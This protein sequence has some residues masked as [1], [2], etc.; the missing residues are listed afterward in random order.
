MRSPALLQLVTGDFI[1][2]FGDEAQLCVRES[3]SARRAVHLE[4]DGQLVM[5]LAP[6]SSREERA[7]LLDGWYRRQLRDRIPALIATWEP[8]MG[9]SVAAWGVKRMRTRWGSCNPQARRIWL[10]L[11]LARRP[12]S[13]LEYV[14]VHE[15]V[16]L[17][18]RGHNRRFY[19]FMDRFLPDWRLA[20]AQLRN[21]PPD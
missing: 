19:A 12:I 10:S 11:E 5:Q 16:H 2:V 13:C 18:E 20:R 7:T 4:A 15:M 8:V 14:V 3:R 21:T 9:V 1:P 17:L 6:G